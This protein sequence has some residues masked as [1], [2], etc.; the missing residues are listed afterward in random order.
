MKE[1]TYIML[2]EHAKIDSILI[3]LENS[4]NNKEEAKAILNKL[5][6]N[7]DKHFF[8]EEKVIFQIF[9][10]LKEGES[11][12]ILELLKQHKDILW[13]IK[14]I[15]DSLSSNFKPQIKELKNIV[16]IHVK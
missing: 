14:T 10:K 11:Q 3:D 8:V 2:K 13:S 12:D 7:L 16:R 1:I 15:Q 5:K 9:N 6:W 4:L